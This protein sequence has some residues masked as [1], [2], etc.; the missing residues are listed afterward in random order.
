LR[1]GC[2]C[3]AGLFLIIGRLLGTDDA[4]MFAVPG[5]PANPANID[6]S[7]VRGIKA[8][9]A[10]VFRARLGS[11]GYNM[12]PYIAHHDGKFWAMWSSGG[13]FE[14]VAGQQ[15]LF[16]TS[17]DA[18][19]W[20]EAGVIAHCDA[21]SGFLYIARSYWIRNG[22]LLALATRAVADN[23]VENDARKKLDV[24]KLIQLHWYKLNE[25]RDGWIFGGIV[26]EDTL[27]NYEPSGLPS[28]QWLMSRRDRNGAVSVAVG[29]ETAI[30]DWTIYPVPE[31]SDGHEMSEPASWE[32]PD[33]RLTMVFR[34][35]S[36]S[37]RLYRSFSRDD[38]QT[39]TMP[40]RTNF[41]DGRAKTY[42]LR[43]RDGRYALA[44]NPRPGA[45][46]VP[47]TLSLSEDGLRFTRIYTLPGDPAKAR[48]PNF[49]KRDGLQYPHLVEVGSHLFIIY[50]RNQEDIEVLHIS[51]SDL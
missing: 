30:G 2:L 36:S 14:D 12:H 19:H 24:E 26:L 9:Q 23:K 51:L 8:E 15:V 10:T 3:F 6:W 27:S 47:L 32:L 31:P 35:Q 25:N 45:T 5:L 50:S 22:E 28:G 11:A 39:W 48:Y 41:P 16:A 34:D 29:G 37:F 17:S 1:L 38:A 40:E 18:V 7:A 21:A 44:N 13:E 20:S 4:L 49:S 46:R 42:V 43:L 33:G